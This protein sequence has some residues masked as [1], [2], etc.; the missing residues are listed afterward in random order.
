MANAISCISDED[1]CPK[2]VALTLEKFGE[3]GLVTAWNLVS[4]SNVSKHIGF[5]MENKKARIFG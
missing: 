4:D 2:T 1:W 5:F 3:K